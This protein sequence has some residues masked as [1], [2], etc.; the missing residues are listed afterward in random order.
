MGD[1]TR[2]IT[3]LSRQ[4]NKDR[5]RHIFRQVRFS[6][7]AH[8]RGMHEIHVAPD[9]FRECGFGRSSCKLAQKFFICHF[10]HR[11]MVPT[12]L[13]NGQF[14]PAQ[15]GLPGFIHNATALG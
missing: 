5:L 10:T 4:R 15:S 6:N 11:L 9:E 8:R 1:S 14:R 13:K 12:F 2:H 7:E 3:S